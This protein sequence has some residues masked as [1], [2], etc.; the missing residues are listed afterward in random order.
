MYVL[1]LTLSS[2]FFFFFFR[3]SPGCLSPEREVDD[4]E[5]RYVYL[6][7]I[8]IHGKWKLDVINIYINFM[9]I[10]LDRRLKQ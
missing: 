8:R 2:L 3:G 4:E 9:F 10:N 5:A 7:V 1:I 6:S